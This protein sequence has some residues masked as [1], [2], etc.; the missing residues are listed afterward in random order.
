VHCVD[1]E[2][3]GRLKRREQRRHYCAPSMSALERIRRLALLPEERAAGEGAK[4]L[5]QT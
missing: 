2:I 4:N 5:S 1:D 3:I